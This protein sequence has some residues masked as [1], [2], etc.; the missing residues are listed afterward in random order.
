MK[1]CKAITI[2]L[3]LGTAGT[4][5]ATENQ[6]VGGLYNISTRAWIGPGIERAVAG[7]IIRGTTDVCVVIRGRGQSVDV[8]PALR[9]PNPKIHLRELPSRQLLRYNL[10]W[11]KGPDIGIISTFGLHMDLSENDAA[12][13]QCL[14]PGAYTADLIS[15]DGESGIGIVEVFDVAKLAEPLGCKPRPEVSME[16]TS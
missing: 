10:D 6:C 13:Y 5:Y 7:F 14:P 11:H 1:I 9:L 4:A 15:Q 3:A 8:R 2:A 12:L 16:E